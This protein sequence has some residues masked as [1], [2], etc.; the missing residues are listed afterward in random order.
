[1]PSITAR[2]DVGGVGGGCCRTA[3]GEAVGRLTG[4]LYPKIWCFMLLIYLMVSGGQR[5]FPQES[6]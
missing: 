4:V 1:M 3:S 2:W 6:P 5:S